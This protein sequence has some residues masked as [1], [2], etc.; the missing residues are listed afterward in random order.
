LTN[1]NKSIAEY[2]V[3][4]PF[5]INRAGYYIHVYHPQSFRDKLADDKIRY[6]MKNYAPVKTIQNQGNVVA[7]IYQM[8]AGNVDEIRKMGY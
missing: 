8:P 3:P 2:F 6:W 1:E 5:D 7:E 4:Y